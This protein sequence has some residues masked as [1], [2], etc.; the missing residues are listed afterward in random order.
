MSK[1]NWSIKQL[2]DLQT[3][4]G[5]TKVQVGNIDIEMGKPKTLESLARK[6]LEPYLLINY[7]FQNQGE[8]K[9]ADSYEYPD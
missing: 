1:I 5:S 8:V 9:D 7:S 6:Y 4:V 3:Y 2:Q